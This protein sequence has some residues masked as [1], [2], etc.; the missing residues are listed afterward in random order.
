[1]P[2]ASAFDVPLAGLDERLVREQEKEQEK[3]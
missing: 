2:L 3:D 1:M